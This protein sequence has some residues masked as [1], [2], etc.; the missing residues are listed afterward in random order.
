M[1][2]WTKR[3]A[4]INDGWTG[5]LVGAAVGAVG[6]GGALALMGGTPKEIGTLVEKAGI[7]FTILVLLIWL[8]KPVAAK[9]NEFLER[10][11]RSNEDMAKNYEKLVDTQETHT[12][13]LHTHTGLL[14][15]LCS[16]AKKQTKRWEN[17]AA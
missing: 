6:A 1:V 14:T 12:T 15:E 4:V 5:R 13:I 10:T 9:H 17:P 11:A 8:L 16:E 2:S 7:P 3:H